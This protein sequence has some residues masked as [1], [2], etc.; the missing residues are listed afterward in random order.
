MIEELGKRAW[1]LSCGRVWGVKGKSYSQHGDQA[2]IISLHLSKNFYHFEL[3]ARG[4]PSSQGA[5]GASL[6]S[7]V[8]LEVVYGWRYG[9]VPDEET[10]G[11]L[12]H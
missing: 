4:C 8:P 9:G 6:D 3:W 10:E 12:M 1:M 11:H 7:K 5:G 2:L